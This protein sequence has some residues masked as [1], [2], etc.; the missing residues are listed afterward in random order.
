MAAEEI[1]SAVI[2][3][4]VDAT[5]VQTGIG[6]AKEA[7]ADLAQGAKTSSAGVSQAVREM[8]DEGEKTSGRVSQAA[9]S[10]IASLER[11][12]LAAG[13]T[14]SEYLA[15]RAAQLGVSEQASGYIAKMREAEQATGK[16]QMSAA[17]LNA[18]LRGV[19]AQFTDIVTQLAG[20]GSPLLVLTQQGGQ[21]KD[22]FGGIGPAAKALGGYVMGLVTPFTVAAAAAALLTLALYQGRSETAEYVKATVLTGNYAGR[23]SGQLA[24]MAREI[25][26][27]TGTTGKAADVLAQLAATGKIAGDAMAPI[28]RAALAM[29][30]ATGAAIDKTVAD[31]VRL[32]D[33]PAK[34]SEKLNEQY[35]YLTAAVWQQ[36]HALEEEG[37]KDEA[38]ALAQKTYAAAMAERAAEVREN[39]G[40]LERGWNT[41]ASAA[42]RAWDAMKDVGRPITLSQIKDKIASVTEEL[43]KLDAGTSGFGETGGGAATGAGRTSSAMQAKLRARLA[44]LT[45]Q[46]APLEAQS[47]TAAIQAEQARQ[48]QARIE[49][50]KRLDAQEKATRTAAQRRKEEIDQLKR[51]ADTVGMAKDEY[52]RRVASIN[53]KYKDPKTAR[54]K[55]VTADAAERYLDQLSQENAAAL[56]RS[57]LQEKASAAVEKQSKFEQLIADIQAKQADHGQK[58]LTADEKSLLAA[59]D[60]IREKLKQYVLNEKIADLQEKSLKAERDFANAAEAINRTMASARESRAEQYD[61]SLS[62]LGLGSQAQEQLNSTKAIYREYQ[63]YQRQLAREAGEKGMLGSE[64]YAAER[65]Q[66]KQQLQLALQD[67]EQYYASLRQKQGDWTLGAQ[68]ALNNYLDSSRNVFSQ[69]ASLVG[70]AFSSMEDALVT[71]TTTGKLNFKSLANSIIA[72]LVRIQTRQS[73]SG[74]ASTLLSSLSGVFGGSAWQSAGVQASG[75]VTS[76]VAG[77]NVV[78]TALAP[79]ANAKGNVFQAPGLH[80]Y[81]N[82]VLE[83]AT[84]FPFAKGAAI[85]VAGEAGP[86]AIM[87]LRRGADGRLGVSTASGGTG[88][89]VVNNYAGVQVQAKRQQRDDGSAFTEI[90]IREVASILGADVAD[91]NGPIARGIEHRYNLK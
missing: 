27:S 56:T 39:L 71:F 64:K 11:Q 78:G 32:A 59:Q 43:N 46:A 23:T 21:L 75:A 8:G 31:F 26:A 45:A 49:A 1:G 61:R 19:P 30:A 3:A 28:A 54:P 40:T 4:S 60:T 24:D 35:H 87:P 77:G 22:M 82:Q 84:L 79:L 58:S 62:V 9:R 15:L 2:K 55:A 42:A 67:N 66:I 50:Q 74:V 57:S 25:S 69:T 80:A 85:G 41:V 33:E 90:L 48:Q 14:R 83:K 34:A 13:K 81:A 68:Q 16:T 5:G 91:G 44:E 47:A 38:S 10:F 7:F 70:N 20:G 86:E 88:A 89:V 17:A 72:D 76:G 36:I 53:E 29:S 6:K 12:A 73:L 18:A 63:T 65:N 51:D 37:R 52:D